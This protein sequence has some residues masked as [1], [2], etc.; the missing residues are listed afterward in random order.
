MGKVLFMRKGETHTAP[1]KGLP[2]GYTK[3]EYIQSTGTQY[4]DTVFEPN[5][6][7]RVIM[8]AEYVGTGS[9][10]EWFFGCRGSTSL[11]FDF[12]VYNSK[13]VFYDAYESKNVTYKVEDSRHL[14]DKNKNVTSIDGSVVNTFDISTFSAGQNLYLLALNNAGTLTRPAPAKLYSCQIYDNDVLVRDFV[15]CIKDDGTVGLYD[16]V[17]KQ[18][19]GNAG[20]GTFTGSEVA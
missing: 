9:T 7:T 20:T 17:G 2:S 16:L 12:C 10:S 18:F 4:I 11:K 8:D 19:Y 1:A 6:D 5:N 15:P 14:I 13:T 3:L